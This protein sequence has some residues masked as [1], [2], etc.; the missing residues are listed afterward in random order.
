MNVPSSPHRRLAGFATSLILIATLTLASCQQPKPPP[1]DDSNRDI[2]HAVFELPGAQPGSSGI[3]R[4]QIESDKIDAYV[5]THP[6][7]KATHAPLRIRQAM[8]LLSV[9]EFNRANAAFAQADSSD[10]H[11]PRDQALKRQQDTLV[12]WFANS[13]KGKW[14]PADMSQAQK[15]LRELAKEQSRLGSS[16]EIR[17]YIAEVRAWIGLSAA[18]Q[19]SDEDEARGLLED[20]LDV[21]AD[22]FTSDDLRILSGGSDQT[23]KAESPT[24][25][26]RRRLRAKAVLNHARQQNKDDALS[27]HP[28]AAVFYAWIN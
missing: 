12:W 23:S 17:D 24:S 4:A 13:R 1:I 14:T 10:L 25:A 28:K 7:E 15:S 11:T 9:Y 3:P 18:R 27:A 5:A 26:Q 19:T 20:A 22:I 6:G 16:E 8:L 2:L 21:Y